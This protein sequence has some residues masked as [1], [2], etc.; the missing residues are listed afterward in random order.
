MWRPD[1]GGI[2][3]R[4]PL[5]PEYRYGDLVEIRGRLETPP[6]FAD[7]DY[8]TYLSHQG[9]DSIVAYPKVRVL[10]HDR[11]S[12]IRAVLFDIR[13]ALSD[14]IAD[15]LASP[16]A[17]LSAGILLGTRSQLPDDLRDDMRTTGTTHL[18]AVSGQNVVLL[19]ALLIGAFAWLIGRR[20]AAW[21][22]LAGILLYAA[23]VGGQPS[24]I[25][26]EIMGALYIVS[27]A[28]GRQN[29]AFVAMGVAAAGMTAL[30]PQIVH[31]V[32]FQFSNETKQLRHPVFVYGPCGG[33]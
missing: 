10:E 8:R 13:T 30:D 32:S 3:M 5:F 24:V 23:L 21:L 28:V 7:F 27:I 15:I 14:S 29:T 25:R 19:A 20:P 2:A 16:E 33:A 31:D 26:A 6:T 1:A 22:A 9:I 17:G 12:P 18:V 11:G 4:V